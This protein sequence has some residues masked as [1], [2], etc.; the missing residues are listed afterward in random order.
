MQRV[1]ALQG[2]GQDIAMFGFIALLLMVYACLMATPFVPGIEIG[3]SLMLLRGAE[4]APYVY[5][6]TVMG[7]GVAFL[8]GRY[9][10][11][12]VIHGIFADLRL[13]KACQM[14]DSLQPLT[15]EQRLDH[16]QS[17]LPKRF[18]FLLLRGRYVMLAVLLNTPGNGFLGGGGGLCLI[19]GLSRLFAGRYTFLCILIAVAPVPVMVWMHG[20]LSLL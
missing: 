4:I 3:V 5:L 19:A 10:P 9:V 2:P 13:R 15:P 11:Y 20:S 8:V 1:Q 17:A 16:L 18:A 7:L 6:A 12:K 14:I